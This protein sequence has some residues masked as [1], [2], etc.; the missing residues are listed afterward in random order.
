MRSSAGKLPDDL[1]DTLVT[2]LLAVNK[3]PL[4]KVWK[5]LP[6]LQDEGL[7]KPGPVA[8]EDLGRLT[9]RLA[10]A[11][12]D[13]GGLTALFAKRLQN[14]MKAIESGQL[15]NLSSAATRSDPQALRTMLCRV[16]GIG[17]HVA[18]NAWILLQ[19]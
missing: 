16:P 5:I 17:L 4:D 3:Y 15:D 14:L 6:H 19:D 13:R 8:S 12:Y 18:Q 10:A 9:I 1:V 11:G 7:T 2:A